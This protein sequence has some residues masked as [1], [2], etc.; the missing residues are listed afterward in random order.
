MYDHMNVL[1]NHLTEKGV[2]HHGRAV[3]NATDGDVENST[4]DV[5]WP[6]KCYLL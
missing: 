1:F 6:Y 5:E 3:Y 2:L 4:D